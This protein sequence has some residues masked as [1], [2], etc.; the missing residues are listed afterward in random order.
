[1]A[2]QAL[3]EMGESPQQV[4][5]H[6]G[7]QRCGD[8]PDHVATHR[9]AAQVP[10][11]PGWEWQ[12]VVACA[13]GSQDITVN[14]A[15][16]VPAPSGQ[17]LQAPDWVPWAQRV[18]PGDLH[19]GDVLPP[20]PH[21]ARLTDVAAQAAAPDRARGDSAQ[22]PWLSR[23]G[24]ADAK[25]RWRRGDFG[26]TSVFAQE[27]ALHCRSCAF[28]VP[29][30]EPIGATFGVCVNELSADGR[31]VHARYGCGAHSRTPAHPV[32]ASQTRPAFDDERPVF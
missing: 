26:P 12:V 4:G 32:A 10:G 1:M 2:R 21:D 9:F 29:A 8:D 3:W 30:A 24:L 11:Y 15:A 22:G 19:P 18:R 14:E 7:A 6:V 25:Q 13:P 28:F 31:L 27:A 23:T 20:E 16:L 5:A 17:A